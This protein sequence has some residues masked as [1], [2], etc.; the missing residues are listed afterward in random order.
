MPMRFSDALDQKVSEFERPQNL[1]IGHYVFQ[2]LRMPDVAEITSKDGAVFDRITFTCQ[3]I[4]PTD[5]VDED[6]LSAYGDI[7][8]TQLR[9]QFLIPDG[10][11]DFQGY[12]RG[13]FALRQFISAMGVDEDLPLG[14][15]LTEAVGGQFRGLVSHRPDKNDPERVYQEIGTTLPVE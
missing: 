15:A 9:K 4:S 14:E 5:D 10:E 11:V 8:N 12:E 6:Q 3:A 13:R 7:T 1:P 2:N